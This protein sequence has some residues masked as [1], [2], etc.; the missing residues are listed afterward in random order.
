MPQPQAAALVSFA[1]PMLVSQLAVRCRD[2]LPPNAYLEV[3]AGALSDRYRPDAA[4]AWPMARRAIGQLFTQFLG[5]PMPADM[6]SD[7]IRT[8][9]EPALAGLLAKRIKRQDCA[10]ADAAIADLAPLSGRAVGRLAA[11]AAAEADRKGDG[12]A[13]LLKVCRLGEDR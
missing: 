13:G 1:L 10:T 5:Q 3:N 9:A 8:L 7:L 11:L 4:A 12:L 6:N 2:D